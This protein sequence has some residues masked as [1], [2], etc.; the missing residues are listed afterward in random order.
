MP[1]NKTQTQTHLER[2]LFLF[3]KQHLMNQYVTVITTSIYIYIYTHTHYCIC[4]SIIDLCFLIFLIKLH[5]SN[6][7]S[8]SVPFTIV[9]ILLMGFTSLLLIHPFQ[10][11]I[12]FFQVCFF[13]SFIL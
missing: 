12:N 2:C 6:F 9:I 11:L 10:E 5:F 4:S 13:L 1:L 8:I 7:F 3:Q